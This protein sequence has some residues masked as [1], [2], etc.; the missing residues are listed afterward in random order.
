[1]DG[2]GRNER[3]EER[4]ENNYEGNTTVGNS[5]S[6]GCLSSYLSR[7]EKLTSSHLRLQKVFTPGLHILHHTTAVPDSES[8]DSALCLHVIL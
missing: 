7:N 8:F 2:E 4:G 1:M 6:L 3:L 5:I